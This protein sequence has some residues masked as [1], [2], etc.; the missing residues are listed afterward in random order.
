M[1][2]YKKL[3]S[4]ISWTHEIDNPINKPGYKF[5]LTF[6][7]SFLILTEIRNDYSHVKYSWVTY[8]TLLNVYMLYRIRTS[9][10]HLPS[11]AD[12]TLLT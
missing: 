4:K 8:N 2:L 9:S 5:D 11:E 6:V 7:S 3:K 12:S 1:K 10:Q